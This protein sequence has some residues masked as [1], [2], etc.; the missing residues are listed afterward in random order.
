VLLDGL[1]TRDAPANP[2]LRLAVVVVRVPNHV[3][4]MARQIQNHDTV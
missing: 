2:V 4:A 3:V 1:R